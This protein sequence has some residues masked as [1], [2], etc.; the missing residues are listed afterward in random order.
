MSAL[1]VALLGLA[2]CVALMGC[3]MDDLLDPLPPGAIAL[4]NGQP[5]TLRMVEARHDADGGLPAVAQN[6]SVELLQQQYGAILA[7]LIVQELVA[8]ELERLGLGVTEEDVDRALLAVRN[9]Y[10]GTSF[11]ENLL[12]EHI[13]EKTWRSLLRYTVALPR[14]S[15]Q[16]LRPKIRLETAEV[17]AWYVEH[18]AEFFVPA[19]FELLSLTSL[20]QK[21]LAEARERLLAGGTVRELPEVHAQHIAL[22]PAQLPEVWQDELSKLGVGKATRIREVNGMFQFVVLEARNPARRMSPVEAYPRIEQALVERKM[23]TLFTAWLEAATAEA[24]VKVAPQLRRRDKTDESP[25]EP[26]REP[27]DSEPIQDGAKDWDTPE[28][29]NVTGGPAK[30]PAVEAAAPGA[31]ATSGSTPA[32]SN[33]DGNNRNSH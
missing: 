11:G 10:P 8:Q 13:D 14:F 22:R 17:E 19:Q 23:E 26:E 31:P 9:D 21:P 6:P 24:S 7:E 1:R 16:I 5:I 15:E 12:A 28:P 3:R 4:V 33:E 2:L 27:R 30:A 32:P 29:V 25:Q 18:A 20:T